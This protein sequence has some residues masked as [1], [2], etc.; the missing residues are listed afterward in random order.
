MNEDRGNLDAALAGRYEILRELGRGGMATVYLARDIR[1]ARL[2][3][4]KVL[5]R[6]LPVDMG[7]RRF[8]REIEIA[9]RLVHPH[10]V[11]LHDSGHVDDVVY[12]VMPYLEGETLRSRIEREGPL[13]VE[14]TLGILGELASA[15]DCAHQHGVV[16]RDIKPANVMLTDGGAVLT[17]FGVALGLESAAARER[18]T[19]P[20]V[21]VGTPHYMPPEQ[22]SGCEPLGTRGDLYALGCVAYEMLTGEPPFGGSTARAVIARHVGAPPPDVRLL[23]PVLPPGF[24][25]VLQRALAKQPADRFPTAVEL[26]DALAEALLEDDHTTQGTVRRGAPS[27]WA[28]R[29]LAGVGVLLVVAA[30]VAWALNAPDPG[31]TVSPLR[32][33]PV[34]RQLTFD[35]GVR[36][37]YGSPDGSLILYETLRDGVFRL[38][39]AESDGSAPTEIF[40]SEEFACCPAWS[41]DGRRIL[42]RSGMRREGR[43]LLIP[44]L[45]GEPRPLPT[46]VV[47]AWSPDGERIVGWWPA[48]DTLRFVDV[49]AGEVIGS[50]PL[51]MP[52]DWINGVDWSPDGRFLTV[53]TSE[54]EA[55]RGGAL[56]TVP[57]EGGRG[58]EIFRDSVVLSSPR[59]RGP[60]GGIYFVRGGEEI[61]LIRIDGDG[62]P[63]GEAVRLA[64]GLAINAHNVTLPAF[65]V[66]SD[67]S[68]L[69]WARREGRANLLEVRLSTGADEASNGGRW[70]TSGTAEHRGARIS[71]DGRRIAFV[72]EDAG[73]WSVQVLD[74]AGG[75]RRLTHL[76]GEVTS[77]AWSPD[78][79]QLAFGR[80]GGADSGV[81]VARVAGGPA[82]RVGG[83]DYGGY[84]ITWLTSGDILY[85]RDGDRSYGIL[86]PDE[87][88]G[89]VLRAPDGV[90]LYGPRG[91]PDGRRIAFRGTGERPGLWVVDLASRAWSRVAPGAL[92]PLA[93]SADGDTLYAMPASSRHGDASRDVLAIPLD[94]GQPESVAR[95]PEGAAM[96]PWDAS[97]RP[98]TD[99][100]VGTVPEV[101][102][103]LWMME[104]FD[105]R[106]PPPDGP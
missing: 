53:A 37:G 85:E 22:V 46:E 73:G 96:N 101:D 49:A 6:D 36:Q 31:P 95:L 102:V 84:E 12:F 78:G 63:A 5:A 26:S 25:P 48:T 8:L 105:R 74:E 23:R 17:D 76:R 90:W 79:T 29:S 7:P 80:T 99:V 41:P 56:W 15:I 50:L 4:L 38:F 64:A 45:G 88:S 62:R 3:A 83:D 51:E 28:A 32:D 11:T 103:D 82:V 65:S 34:P 35:G 89:G 30:A 106:L 77:P 59:W 97:M 92:G 13:T 2:V 86:R 47:A 16:H 57:V 98:G 43:G 61:W 52:H 66:S 1:H 20:G 24:T 71:P 40:R 44:R 75:T 93:W 54:G 27:R 69:F 87:G 33:A 19:E 9:A 60:A 10:I 100:L 39:V 91:S 67:G 68:R 21:S 104:D 42:L 72:V 14:D 70:L 94:G 18:L 55:M 81:W 58:V